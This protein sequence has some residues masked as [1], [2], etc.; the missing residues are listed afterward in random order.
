MNTLWKD[1]LAMMRRDA[2]SFLE[3][4]RSHNF[5]YDLCNVLCF[6]V[7]LAKLLA[8]I[9]FINNPDWITGLIL[10]WLTPL[11]IGVHYARLVMRKRAWGR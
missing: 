7:F 11:L 3:F 6:V 2:E 10:A 4:F 1:M 9:L 5:G 8:W